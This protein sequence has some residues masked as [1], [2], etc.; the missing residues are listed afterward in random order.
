[1]GFQ[2]RV[3]CA[4]WLALLV[5]A[6]GAPG[7]PG[8]TAI[9]FLEKTRARKLNLEPGGDTAL[10]PQTSAE[11]R[12]QIARRLER[13][14][15]DLANDSLETGE[16]M[17]DEEMAGVLI[18][19]S[20]G[21]DPASLRVFAI[22]LVKRAGAWVAAPLPA[23]FENTGLGYSDEI[24][25]RAAALQDWMLRKQVLDLASLRD[26]SANQ[27]RRNIEKSLSA[28]SLRKLDS[29]QV[30]ERFIDACA[31][32][33][34]PE[35]LGLLGGLS[36]DP[37]DDW[38]AR[39]KSATAAA[40][41]P[42]VK[43]PWRLLVSSNILRV[44]VHHEV[45]AGQ[46]LLSLAC[47]DPAGSGARLPRVEFVH[48]SFEKSADG[49]W[50][51]DPPSRFFHETPDNE[52]SQ[53]D[54][55][56]ADLLAAFPKA[57]AELH[58]PSPEPTARQ[59]SEVLLE[60][61]QTGDFPS[62]ARLIQPRGNSTEPTIRAARAWWALHEPGG[63]RLLIPL[64]FKDDVESAAVV[65]QLF[66]AR[67][68][69]RQDLRI[70]HFEKSDAGWLW[71]PQPKTE[72]E[73]ALRDWANKESNDWQDRLLA[74]SVELENL[75]ESGAP[76]E[77]ESRAVVESWLKATA[78][79]DVSAALRLTARLKNP[80]SKTTVLRNLGYEMTG[81]RKSDAPPS[82]TGIHRGGICTAV[83]VRSTADDK[84]AHPLYPVVTTPAGP[85]ILI[86]IDLIA[87]KNRTRDFLNRTALTRLRLL[88][89]GVATE[90]NELF[91]KHQSAITEAAAP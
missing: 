56:D 18:R 88:P 52:E 24:R 29:K 1:M 28:E 35:I 54:S 91:S 63:I 90:V 19:K 33:S 84:P 30:A 85:R 15:D 26:Q 37:P 10:S 41:S 53:D 59:A 34:L 14:A 72:T 77:A 48:L 65:C 5:S 2:V 21:F 13:L 49:L 25:R 27:L 81:F 44:P 73:E 7:D 31:R 87:S 50:R 75:L 23:S 58:P 6:L 12:R 74:D 70:F 32:R 16:L 79:G 51:V 39:L 8:E 69:D 86:E 4:L 62:L 3:I 61:L 43:R 60:R 36:A 78:A 9:R 64:A 89:P 82:I 55:L 11:K 67:S 20:D 66:S 47:L 22:A 68:P 80:D 83:G 17:V 42:D 57:L 38:A 40:R 45:D 76:S 71:N 46:A